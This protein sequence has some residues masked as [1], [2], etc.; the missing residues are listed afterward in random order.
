LT[1]ANALMLCTS[2]VAGI[3]D[4][5]QTECLH[6]EVYCSFIAVGRYLDHATFLTGFSL[7]STSVA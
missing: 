5:Q 4:A 3:A 6:H 2:L 7:G 1:I